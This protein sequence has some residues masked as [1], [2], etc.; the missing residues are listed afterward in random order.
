[1]KISVIMANYRGEAYLQAAMDSVLRQT[2]HDLELIVSDDASGDGSVGLVRAAMAADARVKLVEAPQN[3]GPGAA[4]NRAL[5]LASGDWIAVSD[6][7]DLMHPDR[8]ARLLAAAQRLGADFVADDKL[9]FGETADAS[10]CTLLGSLDLHAPM[11][12]DAELFVRASGM[13]SDLPALGYLKPLMRREGIAGLRYDESLRIG[14]DYDFYLR[15]L[16]RGVRFVALPDP[17]YLYRRH[18]GSI[19]Y[20]LSSP[21]LRAMIAAHDRIVRQTGEDALGRAMAARRAGLAEALR[22]QELVDAIK[23]RRFGAALWQMLRAP[24]LAGALL[25]SLS[26]RLHR[27]QAEVQPRKPWVLWLGGH[28]PPGDVPEGAGEW[29]AP[30]M[31]PEAGLPWQAPPGPVAAHLSDLAA[32]CDLDVRAEG[33]AALWALWLIPRWQTATVRIDAAAR[34]ATPLPI[35]EGARRD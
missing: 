9:F 34:D 18:S 30:L 21:T 6:S 15:A 35:P 2:H 14:E 12:I 28:A 31:P 33:G 17:M 13:S 1:M 23:A 19:S 25:Q 26:Q 29:L 11:E 7:D 4:R 5:D 27:V 3:A 8:L 32:R 16:L 22:Y 24:A 10:G 20:R